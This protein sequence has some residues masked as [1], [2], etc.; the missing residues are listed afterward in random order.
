MGLYQ[1][2]V[3]NPES[4][5]FT[6]PAPGRLSQK[7]CLKEHHTVAAK[8]LEMELFKL[9]SSFCTTAGQLSASNA[10]CSDAEFSALQNALFQS[11]N[12]RFGTKSIRFYRFD[13]NQKIIDF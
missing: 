4:I 5:F 11:Q 3:S 8:S 9:F 1:T 13:H 12:S 10:G 2:P 6:C 7:P